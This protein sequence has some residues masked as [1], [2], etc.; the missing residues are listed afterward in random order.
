MLSRTAMVGLLFGSALADGFD[1]HRL[2]FYLLLAVVPAAAVTALTAFGELLDA[3]EAARASAGL[4]L[5]V[6][7]GV[8][9]LVLIVLGAA[10]RAAALSDAVVPV[11]ATAALIACVALILIQAGMSAG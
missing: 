11:L 2:A 6:L 1:A 9:V 7:L 3:L 10:A 5:Q 4:R 8:L